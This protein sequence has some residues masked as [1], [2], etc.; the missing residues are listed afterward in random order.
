MAE[1]KLGSRN[2]A[3]NMVAMSFL[4]S[5]FFKG[6][7]VWIKRDRICQYADS[8]L[9]TQYLSP[10]AMAEL[11]RKKLGEL[12]CQAVT[13]VPYYRERFSGDPERLRK[14]P[15]LSQ[16]GLLDKSIIR[17]NYEALQHRDIAAMGA[18]KNSTSGSTGESLFF[19]ISRKQH[20]MCDAE[21]FR[22]YSWIGTT[23]LVPQGTLWGARFDNL[24]ETGFKGFM[25]DHFKPFY[26]FSSYD[27]TEEKLELICRTIREK[28]LEVFTSYPSPLEHLA[29]FVK[30][31][32]YNFP[33]LKGIITSSEQLFPYQREMFGQVFG[34]PVFNRYGS[35]EFGFIAHECEKHEGLHISAEHVWVEILNDALQ[36]C[37]P[38]EIGD[39]YI[40]D[41]DNYAMP[42]IR[43]RIGDRASWKG[44]DC[45][46]GRSLPLLE[47]IDG[48]SF[49]LV[50]D[51]SG[52]AVSGTFWTLVTRFVAPEIIAFQL[53]QKTL[54]EAE[55]LL[56]SP[57]KLSGPQEKL[58]QEKIVEKLPDLQISIR[59]VDEIPLTRSGKKRFVTS[60]LER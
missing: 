29:K 10:E 19:L 13:A 39:L 7:H 12:L 55:L 15:D 27:L 49:E 52:H 4:S 6:Y 44:I 28:K 14:D 9:K 33:S 20:W 8:L 45:S 23:P 5:V 40:T 18:E 54:D 31:R 3:Y 35:R 53:H 34:C 58:L 30:T 21:Y 48:R 32:G 47:Q 41:L 59:Y 50:R 56:V 57:Q 42:F 46:C 17:A 16:F 60:D 22:S 11:R 2:I 37:K 26:F 36:P 38:G 51:R 25:R 1:V 24:P 43:Y